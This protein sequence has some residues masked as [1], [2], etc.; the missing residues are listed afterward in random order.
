[1]KK[2]SRTAL[3]N[4]SAKQ[5]YDVVND[6]AR[7]PEFLPWCGG[8][9]VL[10]ADDVSMQA[11]VTIAK[12]GIKQVFKTQNH[13][14]PNQRIEMRLLEGPFSHLQGEWTFKA[15][16]EQACKINFEIEFEV[17]SGLLRVALNNIFEQIANTFVSSFVARAEQIYG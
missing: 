16:D 10:S 2:I 14:T 3:L 15:L 12:L 4:Y 6:V 8:A 7:Y 11:E 13:L 5:M 17:S 1:M 9:K